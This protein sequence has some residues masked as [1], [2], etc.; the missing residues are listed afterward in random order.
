MVENRIFWLKVFRF[1]SLYIFVTGLI[2]LFAIFESTQEPW[3]LFY[4]FLTWPLDGI[5]VS[6]SSGERQLSAILGGVLCGWSWLL[7]SLAKPDIFNQPIRKM[8]LYSIWIW[9]VLDSSGSAISGLPLNA[10]SNLSFF[11]VLVIPLYKLK[12]A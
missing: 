10:V 11:L 1:A 7:Y 8:M 4:D 12:A 9:F 5:P 3:R 6:L 2:P